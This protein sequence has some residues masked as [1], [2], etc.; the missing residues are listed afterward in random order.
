VY[1]TRHPQNAL[2]GFFMRGVYCCVFCRQGEPGLQYLEECEPQEGSHA[3]RY[4][5]LGDSESALG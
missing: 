3:Y 4:S 2:A 1:I 5:H